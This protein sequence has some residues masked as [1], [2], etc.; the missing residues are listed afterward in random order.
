ML[1]KETIEMILHL[2][3][4]THNWKSHNWKSH[5]WKSHNWKSAENHR[6]KNDNETGT[7]NRREAVALAQPFIDSL[8]MEQKCVNQPADKFNKVK[9]HFWDNV[10]ES[11]VMG[12]EGGVKVLG[13]VDC[14]KHENI[15]DDCRDSITM[16]LLRSG[17]ASGV[18]GPWIFLAILL[19]STIKT[20]MLTSFFERATR[21]SKTILGE[22]GRSLLGTGTFPS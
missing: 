21:I 15:M 4:F 20:L 22:R 11:C 18:N 14:K 10:D 6:A 16:L 1:R 7:N 17:L 19:A 13:D 5:N 9:A 3:F 8:S 12:N 2:S